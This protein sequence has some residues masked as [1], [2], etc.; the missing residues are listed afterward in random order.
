MI[1]LND[2]VEI[3]SFSEVLFE[4]S[5]CVWRETFGEDLTLI[6]IGT[7]PMAM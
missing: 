7:S 4:V 1:S 2:R 6:I 5:M 3:N